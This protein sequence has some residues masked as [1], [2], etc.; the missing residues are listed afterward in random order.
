MILFLY[1]LLSITL[2]FC[3][4]FTVQIVAKG[5]DKPIY[6][7]TS[8][9]DA[10]IL[11]VVEQRGIVKKIQN[12]IVDSEYFLDI[13]KLVHNPAWPGDERGLLGLAFHPNYDVKK[14][15]FVH[16][17]DKDGK[18]TVDYIRISEFGATVGTK[19]SG[20]NIQ[21]G[22]IQSNNLS[23]SAKLYCNKNLFKSNKIKDLKLKKTQ[24]DINMSFINKNDF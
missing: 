20:D 17:N 4:D 22:K 12:N 6:V 18:V 21:T 19:I 10:T 15:I 24:S 23:S 14:Y 9:N 11:Y 7:A 3:E 13:R 5:F 16:Y 1:I 2:I 8:P